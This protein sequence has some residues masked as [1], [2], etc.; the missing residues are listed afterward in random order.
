MKMERKTYIVPQCE[1]VAV[2]PLSI[3]A[4][5]PNLEIVGGD[6]NRGSEGGGGFMED[7][8]AARGDWNNIWDGM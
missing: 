6:D 2:E 7:A 8:G 5:S 3:I 1:F 4:T